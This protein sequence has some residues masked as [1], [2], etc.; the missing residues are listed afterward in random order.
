MPLRKFDKS[1]TLLYGITMC[2]RLV[3]IEHIRSMYVSIQSGVKKSRYKAFL[4]SRY[5]QG[6]E[7]RR[8]QLETAI[9]LNISSTWIRTNKL[10]SVCGV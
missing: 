5:Q 7:Y 10:V 4:C 1:R 6:T 3:G 8:K 9:N 2:L